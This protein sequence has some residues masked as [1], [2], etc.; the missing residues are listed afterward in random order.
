MKNHINKIDSK[1]FTLIELLVVIAI[2][3]ILASMLL[4]TLAKAKK[5]AN[6]LKCANN[7][8]QISKAVTGFG[9]EMDG[10]TPWTMTPTDSTAHYRVYNNGGGGGWRGDW[11]WAFDPHHWHCASSIITMDLG[12]AKA[13]LSPSDAKVK[14]GNQNRVRMEKWGWWGA[15]GSQSL[16]FGWRYRSLNNDQSYA[17]CFGA[18]GANGDSLLAFTRNVGG[19]DSARNGY[20]FRYH[21]SLLRR[22][23]RRAHYN[24]GS[25]YRKYTNLHV[26]GGD[27]MVAGSYNAASKGGAAPWNGASATGSYKY[28]SMAGLDEGQG[29]LTTMDGAVLQ[30]D[31]ASLAA[32]LKKHGE[33]TGQTNGKPNFNT[34]RARK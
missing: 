19:D 34:T 20:D 1:A 2:I 21:G 3:G 33:G 30:A 18:D 10:D 31:D 14:G 32:A 6:R 26:N 24:W 4:P 9:T 16:N 23:G 7:L 22:G 5:K 25:E 11:T 15:T 29:N 8:G 13:F 17:I 12:S 28:Y 27:P